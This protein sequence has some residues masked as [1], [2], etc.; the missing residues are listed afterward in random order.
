MAQSHHAPTNKLNIEYSVLNIEYFL[1]ALQCVSTSMW[2]MIN[3]HDKSRCYDSLLSAFCSLHSAAYLYLIPFSFSP[4][5]SLF[6]KTLNAL[7][8]SLLALHSSLF[9]STLHDLR[10]MKF[11]LAA[12]GPTFCGQKVAKSPAI[13]KLTNRLYL[14]PNRI[15][16]TLK[17]PKNTTYFY[18][19][20]GFVVFFIFFYP[21]AF[22]LYPLHFTA[23][24]QEVGSMA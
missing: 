14:M 11:F 13:L 19:V 22:G 6:F 1:D 4:L 24:H 20:S 7:R 2:L 5:S 21:F 15:A 23:Y 18:R 12:A 8:S 3:R 16:R 17:S 10:S 9:F